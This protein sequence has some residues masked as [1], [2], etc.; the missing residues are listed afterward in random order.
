MYDAGEPPCKPGDAGP[1]GRRHAQELAGP[2]AARSRAG[3][4]P[5]LPVDDAGSHSRPI[6]PSPLRAWDG[7]APYDGAQGQTAPWSR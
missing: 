3:D 2:P 6:G 5:E 1:F 7:G 4:L